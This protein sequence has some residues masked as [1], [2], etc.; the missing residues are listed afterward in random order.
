MSS[1]PNIPSSNPFSDAGQ[2]NFLDFTSNFGQNPRFKFSLPRPEGAGLK[3][4]QT[5]KNKYYEN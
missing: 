4:T 2:Q 3:N 1:K 5:I